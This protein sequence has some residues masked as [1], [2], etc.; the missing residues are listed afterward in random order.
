MKH[1]VL[2]E[3]L[4]YTLPVAGYHHHVVVLAFSCLNQNKRIHK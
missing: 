3:A 1:P 2:K 4:F